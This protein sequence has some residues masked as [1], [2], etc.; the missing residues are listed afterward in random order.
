MKT[1]KM[2]FSFI[3]PAYNVG[4]YIG[5]CIKSIYSQIDK[6]AF[7]MEVLVIDDG[8]TDNTYEAAALACEGDGRVRIIRQSNKGLSGARNTGLRE[9][10]GDYI[11]FVDGD[12]FIKTGQLAGLLE[13]I[14]AV[15]SDLVIYGAYGYNEQTGDYTPFFPAVSF[16]R[17]K[18]RG[19]DALTYLLT[20]DYSYGWC[21]WHIAFRRE[22]LKELDGF[23]P[24]GKVSEDVAFMLRIW[25]KAD[26]A[27]SYNN[28][29]YAYRRDNTGSITHMAKFEFVRDL[30]E[31]MLSNI[32]LL[33]SLEEEELKCLLKLNYQTLMETILYHYSSYSKAERSCLRDLYKKLRTIYHIPHKM[34]YHY[35]KKERIVRA[36]LFVFGFHITGLAWGCRRRMLA[37]H[38]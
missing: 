3:V 17:E 34:T 32:T 13:Y 9:A 35:R 27:S 29:V 15:R 31:N 37:H 1:H 19:R 22:F 2:K 7:D 6:T 36:A 24:E 33:G 8:S 28:Y 12:D 11:L 16:E 23:F 10:S 14:S 30:A 26:S 18:M 21:V 38:G 25:L 4:H 20:M 5:N